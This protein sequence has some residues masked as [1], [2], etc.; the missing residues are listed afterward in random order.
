MTAPAA[1][2]ERT[3][4]AV[5]YDG[6]EAAKE[7][8]QWAAQ[9]AAAGQYRL[10]VVH[11]WVWPMFTRKLGP[12]KG[13]EGSGLRRSAEAILAEG[14]DLARAAFAAA[15]TPGAATAAGPAPAGTAADAAAEAP[16]GT[17]PDVEGVMETGLPAA[18][19][20]DAA[21]DA[22][23]LVVSS[24]GL[25]GVLGQLAGSVCLD[26]AGSSPC[27][28]MVIRRLRGPGEAAGPVVVG[29]DGTSRSSAALAGAAR[30]AGVLGTT[31][32]IVTIDQSRGGTREM[33]GRHGPMQG[34]E[35]L[36]H[37]L[38]EARNLAPHLSISVDL[39]EGHA[40]SKELLAAAGGAEV[41]VIGTHN[42]EGGPGNT[43]TTVLNKARCNVLIT[44]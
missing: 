43:V 5:G 8:V 23:L 2:P 42:R 6:S 35:L 29:I 16:A 25:G 1:G 28:L 19:L 27:P 9:Y 37:A 10:R 17:G 24:R 26:L 33:H 36:D 7:A 32:Q 4:V 18:V 44:R 40:A 30:L 11:A 12:V 39:R 38:E 14:V 34:Q 41:L 22:R 31:L 20:R 21:Q 3:T 15:R 13:V